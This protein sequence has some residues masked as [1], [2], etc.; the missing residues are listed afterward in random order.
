MLQ[1]KFRD[2]FKK[3]NNGNENIC[4]FFFWF[5]FFQIYIYIY[6]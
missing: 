3:I 5:N 4:L 2:L 6:K 1:F